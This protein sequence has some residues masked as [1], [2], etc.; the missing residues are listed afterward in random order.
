[1]ISSF[2]SDDLLRAYPPLTKSFPQTLQM[3]VLRLNLLS[4]EQAVGGPAIAASR[5]QGH[6]SHWSAFKYLSGTSVLDSS[7]AGVSGFVVLEEVVSAIWICFERNRKLACVGCL[8]YLLLFIVPAFYLLFRYRL[9]NKLSYLSF[10]YRSS[11]HFTY[12]FTYR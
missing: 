6:Q 10:R 9:E 4:N 5:S 12:R 8:F 3:S 2:F 11:S 7:F 1:M